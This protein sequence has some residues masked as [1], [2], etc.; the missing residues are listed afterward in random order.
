MK[1]KSETKSDF[2]GDVIVFFLAIVVP[3]YLLIS[4]LYERS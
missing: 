3:A 2:I 4:G 1:V